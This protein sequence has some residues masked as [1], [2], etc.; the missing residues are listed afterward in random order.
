[1]RGEVQ[2]RLRDGSELGH[3][4]E[5]MRGTRANPTTREDFVAKFR[6]NTLDVLTPSLVQQ[7]IDAILGLDRAAD[8]SG[9][10]DPLSS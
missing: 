10:F 8:V 9:V 4:V 1:M 6:A 5:D 2:I 7:T 3:R